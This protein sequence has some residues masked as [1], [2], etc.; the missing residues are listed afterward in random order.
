MCVL[1]MYVCICNWEPNMRLL[2]ICLAYK[3][4]CDDVNKTN[5]SVDKNSLNHAFAFNWL[6]IS[7][8]S[9]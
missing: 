6:T 4:Q 3:V 9:Q 1:Y 5:S 2:T 8:I 7:L